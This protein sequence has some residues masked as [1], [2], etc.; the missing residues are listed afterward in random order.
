MLHKKQFVGSSHSIAK[1]RPSEGR[2]SLA[3]DWLPF[4]THLSID[5]AIAVELMKE[6]LFIIVRTYHVFVLVFTYLEDPRNFR[7]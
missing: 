2:P 7:S 4:R 5:L 6:S 3:P 1:A